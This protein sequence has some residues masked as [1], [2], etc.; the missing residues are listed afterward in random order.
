MT[1][2]VVFPGQGSQSVGMLAELIEAETAAASAF[3]EADEV[4]GFSL[5][6]LVRDGPAEDLGRT[7][8]TQPAMLAAGVAAWRAWQARGGVR[9]VAMAGHSL[10]EYT[11]LVCAGALDFGDALRIVR[12]RG[13]LMQQAVPAG[14]GAMAAVL[15]LDDDAVSSACAEAESSGGVVEAVNFN[16][17]GQ[18]VIAGDAEAVARAIGA[19]RAAGAR[20]ALPLPVSVPSHCRLMAP[21][22][23]RLAEALA[24]TRLL[25]P[26][27]PVFHNVDAAARH[28]PEDIRHALAE[29]VRRPVRWVDCVRALQAAGADT[30]LEAGPGRVL[31]GLARRID[32]QLTALA[33]DDPASL[34]AALAATR[35]T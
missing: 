31:T 30:L 23:D 22:A 11:A 33:V 20:R 15:G 12:L 27:I 25:E 34:E 10:G 8:R 26:T 21:V 5:S 16:A 9:P 29:Q 14:E 2:A 13:E 18:V 32:R 4:L 6:G 28:D 24:A 7:D 1:I 3:A 19:A 35:E 17:P